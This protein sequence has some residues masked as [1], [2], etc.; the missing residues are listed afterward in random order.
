M[1]TEVVF[2]TV[3]AG[4]EQR[5]VL[6]YYQEIPWLFEFHV[7]KL[8]QMNCET[9]ASALPSRLTKFI[10]PDVCSAA[11]VGLAMAERE[12]TMWCRIRCCSMPELYS[13]IAFPLTHAECCIC[14]FSA[15][16]LA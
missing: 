8:L 4:Q 7:N 6:S 5:T 16:T 10:A 12:L 1:A 11:L 2:K 3:S 15:V 9:V 13:S 14:L